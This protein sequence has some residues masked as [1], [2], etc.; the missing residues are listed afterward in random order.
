MYLLKEEYSQDLA[1]RPRLRKKIAREIGTHPLTIKRW[2]DENHPNLTI[3]TI[4][5]MLSVEHYVPIKSL[6]E[7]VEED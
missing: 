3:Y 6:V 7:R 2:A 1:E 4:L 5:E